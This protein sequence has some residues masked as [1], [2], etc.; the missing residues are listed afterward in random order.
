MTEQLLQNNILQAQQVFHDLLTQSPAATI[1]LTSQGRVLVIADS[2]PKLLAVQV[3][4]QNTAVK[5]K[6]ILR[7]ENEVVLPT[8]EVE[9]T[10]VKPNCILSGVFTKFKLTASELASINKGFT[11]SAD[12]VIDLCDQALLKEN[13]RM[14]YFTEIT[15]TMLA[16]VEALTGEFLKPVYLRVNNAVCAYGNGLLEGC[17]EC[18]SACEFD[19]IKVENATITIDHETCQG[20]GDCAAVCPSTAIGY[21]LPIRQ[22]FVNV[23][24]STLRQFI[25]ETG[26]SPVI[27][28]VNE[29]TTTS[30]SIDI[31]PTTLPEITIPLEEQGW[32]DSSILLLSLCYGAAAV[33]VEDTNQATLAQI[34]LANHLLLL[35]GYNAVIYAD[36]NKKTEISALN[37]AI[38]VLERASIGDKHKELYLALDHLFIQT[39]L[40]AT[41]LTLPQE[42]SLGEILIQT[43]DCTLCLS[44]V[45]ACPSS[46]L[47]DMGDK[48]GVL[49]KEEN[50][51]QCGLCE[52]ACPE[53]VIT[54]SPRIQLDKAECQSYRVLNEDKILECVRCHTPFVSE[55][56]IATIEKK[57][58]GHGMFADADAKKRL[59]MCADCRV[60]DMFE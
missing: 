2:L 44:C 55:K 25:G 12:M 38:E 4:L 30:A 56:M 7:D 31:A 29:A 59:R 37:P 45:G 47:Q 36:E 33:V 49:F 58:M 23:L 19:A 8:T 21:Q 43:N 1:P 54:L 5:T 6:F 51:L 42:A 22:T 50:C 52:S 48:P 15:T 17:R 9:V 34:K 60:K 13:S 39:G 18:L 53:K 20:S 27:R 28:F 57:L 41:A 11:L 26:V 40:P 32:L 10:Q 3:Q 14:G 16:E 35:L 24:R 46:A